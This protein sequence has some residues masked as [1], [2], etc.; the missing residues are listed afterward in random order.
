MD[1][2]EIGLNIEPE[3][4]EDLPLAAA[5]EADSGLLVIETEDLPPAPVSPPSLA[6]LPSPNRS[7]TKYRKTPS[8][9]TTLSWGLVN[10][11][12]AGAIG[13]FLAWMATEPFLNDSSENSR[14]GAEILLRMGLYSGV[15]GALIGS[16]LGATEGLG[17]RVAE[18]SLRGAVLGLIIGFFGGAAGGVCG[19]MLYGG[20]GGGESSNLA[21]QIM[22]R[23]LSWGLVGIGVG[24]AQGALTWTPRKLVNGMLGGALGGLVGGFLFDP[25]SA[26]SQILAMGGGGP[27]AAW[28]SRMLAMTVLGACT[29]TAIG[30]V[31]ELRKE[32]W[33]TVVRG[34]LAGKQFILYRPVTVVGSSP[35][36][37]ICLLKDPGIR[38]QHAVLQETPGGHTLLASPDSPVFVNNHTVTHSRLTTGDCIVLGQTV[39]EYRERAVRIS[40]HQPAPGLE[41]G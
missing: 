24:I 10:L 25:I 36:V 12:L 17:A 3:D 5:Q 19:Q 6:P 27:H 11:L 28:F 30:L 23:A 4:L 18:K 2:E 38:P 35:K 33:L 34:P 41:P 29:G 15:L 40:A 13:G 26:I 9:G 1:E 7:S 21:Q 22:I 32:A 20:L 31:E 14:Q 16:A 39:L 37:D 8:S